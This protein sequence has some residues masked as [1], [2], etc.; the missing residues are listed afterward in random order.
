MIKFNGKIVE[1]NRFPDGSLRCKIPMTSYI[2][3]LDNIEVE[4]FL[5]NGGTITWHYENDAEFFT[6]YCL[7]KALK[8]VNLVLPYVPHSR[9]DRIKNEDEVF[10]L[11]YFCEVIN[12]L[13]FNSVTILDPHSNVAPA[14]LD[15]IKVVTS[16]SYV[17]QAIEEI[18]DKENLILFTPDEGAMKRYS[19]YEMFKIYPS[20]FG[21]KNRDWKTGKILSYEILHPEVVKGK[22]VLI[23]DDICSYGGTFY[24]AAK[25]LKAAGAKSVSL[26]VTHMEKSV[27]NGDMYKE[28]IMKNIYT[29]DSLFRE[30]WKT[31]YS[32]DIKVFETDF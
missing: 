22:D 26:F 18:E 10:T 17:K 14:L 11:K 29:T 25:A 21:M 23:I 16:E 6:L 30:E 2:N 31:P 7:R 12:D 8:K 9:M 32:K 5:R 13:K 19:E 20:T 27:F 28:D 3:S 4:L 1:Q 24:H 15:R